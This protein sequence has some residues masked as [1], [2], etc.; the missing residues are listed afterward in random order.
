MKFIKSIF[1]RFPAAICC[2][3][4]WLASCEPQTQ[5]SHFGF[6][7]GLADTLEKSLENEIINVWYPRIIDSTYGGYFTNFSATWEKLPRQEK[8]IVYTARHVW[9]TSM[10]YKQ[11]PDSSQYLDYA[12]QGFEFMKEHLWDD[13]YGGYYIVVS[14]EGDPMD[15]LDLQKRVYGQAFAIYGL[16]EYYDAC[17]EMEVLDWAKKSFQWI[18]E[19]ARDPEH[20]G[21]FEFLLRQGAPMLSGDENKVDMSDRW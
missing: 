16:A 9:T 2:F 7:G 11:Y 12:R 4:I 3:L 18:E 19:H 13:E 1:L 15:T 10:L 17:R 5:N 21:Y 14:Q 8:S 20:G 6:Y